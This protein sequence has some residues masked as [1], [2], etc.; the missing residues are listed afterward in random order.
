MRYDGRGAAGGRGLVVV[1]L[2]AACLIGSVSAQPQNVAQQPAAAPATP[3]ASRSYS[4]NPEGRRDPFVSLVARGADG[5]RRQGK[6]PE[7]A[8]GLS[9]ADLVLRGVFMSHGKYLAIIQGPDNKSFTVRVNDRLF[10]G[11]VKAITPDEIV[12][13]QEVND[14]LSVNKQREVRKPLRFVSEPK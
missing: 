6:P 5:Q 7:G 12:L 2:A 8:A 3:S 4:Y 1:G 10:D 11:V 13:V 9:V 14:P